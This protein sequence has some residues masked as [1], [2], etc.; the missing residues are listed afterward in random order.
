[1]REIERH[2][3]ARHA[4]GRE[5]FLRQ[6][7]VRPKRMPRRS[8]SAYSRCTRRASGERSM[9][10]FRSQ[11]RSSS[12]SSSERRAQGTRRGRRLCGR[13]LLTRLTAAA[14][15]TSPP[16]RWPEA[17]PGRWRVARPD[18]RCAL[19][20]VSTFGYWLWVLALAVASHEAPGRS[21]SSAASLPNRA[22]R[23]ET[24]GAK[25]TSPPGVRSFRAWH[26][27]AG[28]RPG[29]RSSPFPSSCSPGGRDSADAV[30]GAGE[31]AVDGADHVR[32][33]AEVGGAQGTVAEVVGGRNAQ[34][35]ACSASITLPACGTR[36][37]PGAAATARALERRLVPSSTSEPGAS[38]CGFGLPDSAPCSNAA[39]TRQASSTGGLA[40]GARGLRSSTSGRRSRRRSST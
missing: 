34:S 33:A 21:H 20:I 3:D 11:K 22:E 25:V 5:P 15:A 12:S 29:L 2:G 30:V 27:R 36:V 26:A 19:G 1:M 7:H 37:W 13:R 40:G 38:T 9:E 14:A 31:L 18:V 23:G 17:P 32:V 35:A 28:G 10:S 8:S 6:P 4:V 24:S 16:E 39:S